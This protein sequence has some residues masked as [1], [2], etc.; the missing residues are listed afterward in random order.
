MFEGVF[1]EEGDRV[2][3]TQL[4][5]GPWHPQHIHGGALA[6]L[7]A[8][9]A[10]QIDVQQSMRI[11]RITVDLMRPAPI[12]ELFVHCDV[13]RRGR[14]LQ[15]CEVQVV[16]GQAEVARGSVLQVR[17]RETMDGID[18]TLLPPSTG[19]PPFEL[20]ETPTRLSRSAFAEGFEIRPETFVVGQLGPARAWFRQRR[21][22]VDGQPLSAA[23]RAAAVADY[24]SGLA[25]VVRWQE[26][27]Y[28]NGDIS[29][30]LTRL[31]V[32]EWIL[33][34]A[35]SW[36]SPDGVGLTSTRLADMQGYFGRATQ[37]LILS[38]RAA[39]AI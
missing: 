32:G 6:G 39:S 2:R 35:E 4:A 3:A 16:V 20:A 19:A 17:R 1:I 12:G 29:I 15:L 24:S 27:N 38:R 30:N 21:P 26:W 28:P 23:I 8:W 31:P 33:S 10:E 13:V 9:K 7:I 14:M 5:G 18:P 34:D 22:L 37:T 11:A 36:V 25:A